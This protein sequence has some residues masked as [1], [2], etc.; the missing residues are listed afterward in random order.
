MGLSPELTEGAIKAAKKI[1]KKQDDGSMKLKELAKN[2]AEKLND[3]STTPRKIKKLLSKSEVFALDGKTISLNNNNNKRKETTDEVAD[4]PASTN[5]K[6]K[7]D[8]DDSP[9]SD[10][11]A[12]RKQHKIVL[13]DTV[14]DDSSALN[15]MEAYFPYTTFTAAS[16]T[17]PRSLLTHCTVKNGFTKPSPIQAQCWPVLLGGDSTKRDVVGI[18]ETGSGKT[19]AF[20]MPALA[21]MSKGNSVT[22]KRTPRMLVLAPTRELAMQSHD[23]L[24]EFGKVVKL[25]SLVVYGG[26]PK[27]TQ[28]AELKKG[29]VD[30]IVATPGRLKDLVDQGSCDL[31][32]VQ[33]LVLDEAGT[34]MNEWRFFLVSV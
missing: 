6:Q 15:T 21:Q 9:P 23:V 11:D 18:A 26:V 14:D 3:E 4:E 32:Q 5:K 2:V 34:C 12:W 16:E 10:M 28:V 24:E 7:K 22:K 25:T 17:I 31:S 8:D 19:L 33:H 1:L 30:C 27:H 20:A 29:T 13:K